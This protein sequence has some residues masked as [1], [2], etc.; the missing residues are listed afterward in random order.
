M[1][2]DKKRPAKPIKKSPKTLGSSPGSQGMGPY[3]GG[4]KNNPAII[5]GVREQ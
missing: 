2:N 3:M 4:V 5:P 1:S